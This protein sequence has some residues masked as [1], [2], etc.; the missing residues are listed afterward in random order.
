MKTQEIFNLIKLHFRLNWKWLGLCLVIVLYATNCF[1]Q[2]AYQ[3]NVDYYLSSLNNIRAD[4]LVTMMAMSLIYTFLTAFRGYNNKRKVSSTL[5]MP[6]SAESK[7]VAEWICTSILI[8]AIMILCIW[9]IELLFSTILYNVNPLSVPL[10]KD[11]WGMLGIYTML[12]SIVFFIGAAGKKWSWL[13]PVII[14]MAI[15]NLNFEYDY[16]FTWIIGREYLWVDKIL[17]QLIYP[18]TVFSDSTGEVINT[19]FAWTLPVAMYALAYLR[20]K[21]R[22]L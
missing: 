8:P 18:A 14:G 1:S 19:L 3:Y 11:I 12:Q 13:I 7:F 17:F 9:I 2:N 16:P 22:E 10:G 20:L 6:A 5:L 4:C 15:L 21:V